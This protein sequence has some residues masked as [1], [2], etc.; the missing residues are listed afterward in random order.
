MQNITYTDVTYNIGHDW[1]T[2]QD[3]KRDDAVITAELFYPST[4]GG[5]QSDIAN[6]KFPLIIFAHG[7]QQVYSDYHNLWET[8]VPK[9]YIL[10]FLTT[11]QGLTIYIDAYADDISF[12]NK[13]LSDADGIYDSVIKGHITQK[14]ALMGHST[15]GGAIYLSHDSAPHSTTIIS[16][17]ALGKPYTPIYG[18]SPINIAKDINVPSLLLSGD[19]DCITP[20]TTHQ[21]PLYDNLNG[22]KYI[23]T[24]LGG[25]HCGFS[26]S[27]NCPIAESMSCGFIFQGNTIDEEKQR[28]LSSQLILAWVDHYLKNKAD[29]WASFKSLLKD[30]LIKYDTTRESI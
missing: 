4:T 2:L 8:L 16:L 7:Y 5:I 6:K 18:S 11:Q 26:D 28:T 19:K 15:G 12:L 30:N 9:G 29:A 10:V 24:I 13:I 20:P 23:S 22:V 1:L 21:K 25:D 3:L 14:S 17:A 27:T